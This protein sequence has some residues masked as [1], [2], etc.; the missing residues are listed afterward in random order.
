MQGRRTWAFSSALTVAGL[1]PFGLLAASPFTLAAEAPV[2]AGTPM[3]EQA[4]SVVEKNSAASGG[5]ERTRGFSTPVHRSRAGVSS[6]SAGAPSSRSAAGDGAL[7]G[8][9]GLTSH[10]GARSVRRHGGPVVSAQTTDVDVSARRHDFA[11]P[12][13]QHV[14][15]ATTRITATRLRERDVVTLRGLERVAPNLTMQ[16]V[17]GTASNNFYLRG[18][19]FNDF[20]QNNMGPVLTYI[21]DVAY[22]Y[23]TMSNGQMFDLAGATVTPGPVGTEHGQ[24]DTGGEVHLHTNDPTDVWHYGASQD[25]AS[26]ARSRSEAYVSGPLARGLSFRLAGQTRHGGGGRPTP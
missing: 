16:S 22:P 8:V 26:Y 18:A 20:T 19:G 2:Q 13:A 7:R 10:S 23:S 21:D 6:Q 1:L 25:I 4:A 15:D 12:E 5:A 3:A 14:A 9:G 17:N 11:Y 24:S